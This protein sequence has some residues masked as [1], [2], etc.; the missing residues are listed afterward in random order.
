MAK[1]GREN[2]RLGTPSPYS[3][4]ACRHAVEYRIEISIKRPLIVPRLPPHIVYSASQ[5]CPT[6]G[7]ACDLDRMGMP[8]QCEVQPAKFLKFQ[9]PHEDSH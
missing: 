3:T 5:R 1:H 4:P 7:G 6:N 8:V 2:G 9:A